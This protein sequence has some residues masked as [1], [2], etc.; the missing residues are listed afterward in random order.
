[1]K[2][3]RGFTL[4][5]I[6]I[7]VAIIA[8]LAAI[9]IPNILRGR[10]TANE[11]AA[12]GNLRALMSSVEMYRSV[13]QIYPNPAGSWNTQ[14]YGVTPAFG[15]P[16]FSNNLDGNEIIQGYDYEY[17]TTDGTTF[18]IRA[19]PDVNERTGTRTFFV[20]DSGQVQHC[21]G[22]YVTDDIAATAVNISE[23]VVAC[24]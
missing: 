9:A 18:I 11:S 20:D 16:A 4:V 23:P 17:I 1:M 5:E 7:V 14:M 13:N 3:E 21:T 6:M 12:I 22:E 2:H 19:D 15:P 8:L 10:T 24:P